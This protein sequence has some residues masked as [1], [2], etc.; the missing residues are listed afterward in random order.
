MLQSDH[1]GGLLL[2]LSL[3]SV[4]WAIVIVAI[5]VGYYILDIPDAMGSA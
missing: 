4:S 1:L 5:F 3:E 2:A